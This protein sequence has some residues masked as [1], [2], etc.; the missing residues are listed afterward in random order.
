MIK[1]RESLRESFK[2]KMG[3]Q[4]IK[5]EN[6]KGRKVIRG[7]FLLI[8]NGKKD[9]KWEIVSSLRFCKCIVNSAK[10]LLI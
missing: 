9:E 5:E 7:K 3:M 4:K 10:I 8:K 2:E 6:S 1:I